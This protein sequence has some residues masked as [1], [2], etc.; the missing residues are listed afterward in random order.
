MMYAKRRQWASRWTWQHLT[1]GAHS[2]QRSD[3]IHAAIRGF[4]S[5]RSSLTHLLSKLSEY[6]NEKM[7][8]N[9]MRVL[10]GRLFQV[11]QILH[12]PLLDSAADFITPFAWRHQSGQLNQAQYYL[13]SKED[14]MASEQYHVQRIRTNSTHN[15]PNSVRMEGANEATEQ[16]IETTNSLDA[17]LGISSRLDSR[18][19][20]LGR[21]SCQY[22][23]NMGLPCRHMLALYIHK[24]IFSFK[25]DEFN[26]NWKLECTQRTVNACK[27]FYSTSN[28]PNVELL[29]TREKELQTKE[30]VYVAIQQKAK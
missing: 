10:H 4:L 19:T 22:S 26:D 20:S 13:V 3:S 12:S 25:G 24:Q 16:T 14:G 8:E 23:L 27:D 18:S 7:S 29:A 30:Q 21:C 5:S 28:A 11:S 9:Y 6:A 15:E 17:E 1:Q 2:T